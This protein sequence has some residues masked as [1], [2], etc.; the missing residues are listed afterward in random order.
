MKKYN[1]SKCIEYV[2]ILSTYCLN[3]GLYLEIIYFCKKWMLYILQILMNA[4]A[5]RVFMETARIM[6][7]PTPVVVSQATQGL[8]ARLVRE[9]VFILKIVLLN[10]SSFWTKFHIWLSFQ[11]L[12]NV[13]VL[14]A[15]SGTVRTKSID[16][17]VIVYLAILD[18]FVTQVHASMFS[19]FVFQRSLSLNAVLYKHISFFRHWWMCEFPV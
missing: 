1:L 17:F 8:S 19:F 9:F 2:V 7:I 14:H 6:S 3:L 15:Y 11:I 18:S 16:M 4:K 12:M 10:K 5:R 13:L